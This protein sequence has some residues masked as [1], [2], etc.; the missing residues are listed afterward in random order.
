MLQIIAIIIIMLCTENL[1]K[2]IDIGVNASIP[3]GRV[4]L[5]LRILRDFNFKLRRR[6]IWLTPLVGKIEPKF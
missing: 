4:L 2:G 6:A 5:I 1:E 3:Q